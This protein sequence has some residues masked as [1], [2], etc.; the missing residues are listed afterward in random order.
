MCGPICD[1]FC[2]FGNVKDANG[3]DTCQ[4]N[5]PPDQPTSC[6]RKNCPSPAPGAP[7]YICP[8]GK[9]IAGPACV[10][11]VGGSCGWVFIT[12][13]PQCVQNG[14]CIAGAHWDPTLCKCVPAPCPCKAGEV[15]VQQI[16]GPAIK[17]PPPMTCEVPNPT[18]LLPKTSPCACLSP[19]DGR[20]KPSADDSACVCDNGIR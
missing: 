15:C 5:P 13:P 3:C 10:T 20:C 4:C 2:E 6:D 1:I 9:T 14:A 19:A 12:C 11:Q 18:C 16:G 7:N 17:D 8:D